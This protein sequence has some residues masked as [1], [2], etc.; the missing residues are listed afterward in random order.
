MR[1]DHDDGYG[2]TTMNGMDCFQCGATLNIE[3]S[4]ILQSIE[5]RKK[6]EKLPLDSLIM[7]LEGNLESNELVMQLKEILEFIKRYKK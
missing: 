3:Q 7:Y 5:L 4:Y 2:I 1:C 6:L